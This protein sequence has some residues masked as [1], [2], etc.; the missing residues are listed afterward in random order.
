MMGLENVLNL[1]SILLLKNILFL[2]IGLCG[3]LLVAGGLF[4][5]L[6]LVGVITRLAAG[7]RTAKNLMLYEDM[8]LLGAT[9][10]NLIYLYEIQVPFGNIWLGIMG[11]STGIFTG[12]LAASLAEVVKMMPV[13]SERVSLKEGMRA[14]MVMFALGKMAGA[15][16]DFFG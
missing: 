2:V 3:G 5:F 15:L 9:A 7:T 1:N 14:I 13:L 4:A 16:F 12:C 11:L 8:A 6:A 10:G